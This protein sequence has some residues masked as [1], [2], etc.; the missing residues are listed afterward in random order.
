MFSG[1][2]EAALPLTV[3]QRTSQGMR[4]GFALPAEFA[5]S[6]KLGDSIAI[7]GCCLTVAELAQGQALFDAIPETLSLT[8]LGD[9]QSGSLVNIERALQAGARLD[10]HM[11][12]GHVDGVGKISALN[13]VGGEWRVKVD[14]GESFASMCVL[15]GSV[16]LDGISLTIAELDAT[17][18]TVA[19]IPHTWSVTHLHQARV[20]QRINLEADMIGKY[21]RSHLERIFGESPDQRLLGKLKAS[22]FSD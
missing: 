22:G 8:N 9:L 16:C 15:K 14:T 21:V 20:G 6:L 3:A 19:I 7:N 10:G 11:V 5:A 18:L 2:I 4:L 13:Q 17:S 12:Q 1:I